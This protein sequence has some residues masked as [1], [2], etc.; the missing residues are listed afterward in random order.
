MNKWMF[1]WNLSSFGVVSNI[2]DNFKTTSAISGHEKAKNWRVKGFYLFLRDLLNFSDGTDSISFS[3]KTY[4][5]STNN[6]YLLPSNCLH[7]S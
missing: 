3:I 6:V 4:S 1:N 7:L 2:L 5:E